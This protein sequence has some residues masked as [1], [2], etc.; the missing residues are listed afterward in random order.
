MLSKIDRKIEQ[1]FKLN[2][3]DDLPIQQGRKLKPQPLQDILAALVVSCVA[4]PMCV[5]IAILSGAPQSAGLISGIIGGLV[6]G[7]L[8]GSHSSI[9]GPSAGLALVVFPLVGYVGSFEAFLLA[10]AL[11]G[12]IQIGFGVLRLGGLSGY[13]P[14]SVIHGL[15][16]AV[17][18]I[19]VLK[20]IPHLLGHDTDPEG[21]MSFLQPDRYNTFSE[22]GTLIQGEIHR[23]S[24][25][26]G[27]ATLVLLVALQR[28]RRGRSL[29]IPN[30]LMAILAGTLLSLLLRTLGGP[31]VLEGKQLLQMPS[32]NELG[33]S[34]FK[35]PDWR[36]LGNFQVYSAA[37]VI[38]FASG[39]ETLINLSGSDRIDRAGRYS[40]PSRE[41]LSLGIG[42]TIAGL[43]GGIPM[44]SSIERSAVNLEAGARSKAAAFL[45]G[46]MILMAVLFLSPLLSLVPLSVLAAV[47]IVTGVG[48]IRPAVLMQFWKDGKLQWFPFAVTL[49]TT[50]FT[51][52]LIGVIIGLAV[53]VSSILRSNLRRP[54]RRI[55]ERHVAGE[56]L[57]IELANQVSFLNRPALERTLREAPEGCDIL[58]DA[59]NTDFIDPDI[60]STI[61]Q[62]KSRSDSGNWPRVSLR[63]FRDRYELDDEIQFID[64]TSREMQ[65]MLTPRQALQL[66][67]DG[68]ERFVTN[69]RL[70]RDLGRQVEAT[71]TGQHPFAAILGCID[72]RAPVET[73]LDCGLGDVFSARVAGNVIGSKVLGSLEF[74]TAIVKAKLILVLGHT[75]CGAIYNAVKLADA[76]AP[77]M[78]ATGCRYLETILNEITPS[79]DLSEYRSIKD[80]DDPTIHANYMEN[81]AKKNVLHTVNEI[82]AKSDAIRKLV[83][84]GAV[85]VVGAIYDVATGRVEFL[86]DDAIGLD[87]SENQ[88]G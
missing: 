19:L 78:D 28:L 62:Y 85:A 4:I 2:Q 52:L 63:G 3:I 82:V 64:Y 25:V 86:L 11:A 83:D 73:I 71:A 24:M 41:L 18:I 81:V 50:I 22:L 88:V 77:I 20:Q 59:A 32:I 33:W 30:L 8:S 68:N 57:H 70:S 47:L 79:F 36:Q 23:G 56:V 76:G 72:S 35:F 53:A 69:H 75:K 13:F 42:N 51:S 45:N 7:F 14:S 6:V 27:L 84:E 48:L 9:T 15:V 49:V 31:W 10:V 5:G 21:D 16:S 74:A 17:G 60:L 12:L 46:G 29:W 39:L 38:A 26:V 87:V 67:Q 80:T 1:T 58:I 37:F 61:R 65:T 54:L 66:L 44:S 34:F 43:M 40:P 55:S